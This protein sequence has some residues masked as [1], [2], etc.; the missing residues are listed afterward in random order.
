MINRSFVECAHM[1]TSHSQC[2]SPQSSKVEEFHGPGKFGIT[3]SPCDDDRWFFWGETY[4]MILLQMQLFWVPCQWANS[5][6]QEP[7][8]PGEGKLQQGSIGKNLHELQS[9][10]SKHL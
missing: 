3:K 7:P 1:P 6:T 9:H 5:A 10:T 2:A 8:A 4:N